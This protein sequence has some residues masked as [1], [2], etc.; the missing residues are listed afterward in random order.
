MGHTS[1]IRGSCHGRLVIGSG[2]SSSSSLDFSWKKTLVLLRRQRGGSDWTSIKPID[3]TCRLTLFIGKDSNTSLGGLAGK[4]TDTR[5]M[6][7][8]LGPKWLVGWQ[9]SLESSYHV[10]FVIRQLSRLR[11]GSGDA[12]WG[13]TGWD[14]IVCFLEE[15]LDLIKDSRLI[16]RRSS[17]FWSTFERCSVCGQPR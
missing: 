11:T 15:S 10:S 14:G 12:S 7:S 4:S 8:G 13:G 2:K 17:T 16:T 1:D 6:L 9:G 5:N 3:M